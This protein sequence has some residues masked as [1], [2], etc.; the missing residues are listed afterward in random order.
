MSLRVRESDQ[1]RHIRSLRELIPFLRDE[2]DWPIESEDP[3]EITFDYEPKDLGIDE[4]A[5]VRIKEIKQLRPLAG[6]QPWGI[7]WVSFEKKRLPIVVLRRIL[8]ALVIKKRAG[9]SD[10]ATWKSHDLLFLSAYGESEHRELAIAHFSE[11]STG[12]SA[13][14]LRVL[15][16]DDDDTALKLD[17][18]LETLRDKLRWDEAFAKD[19]ERWRK[20]WSAAFQLRY[21]H[22]IRTSQELATALA[23]AA[24]RIKG[25][26]RSILRHEDGL[27]EMRKLQRAFQQ[28]LI[29]DLDDEAFSDMFAQ[30]VTYGLFSMACRRTIPGEGT[31]FA[32]EDLQHYF[33]SPFLKEMF[34]IFL[35]IKTRKGSIDFDELGLSDVTDLLTG[36]DTKMDAVLAD[37]NNKT[38]GEDPVIHFYEHFLNAY[39]K[40]LKVQRGVFYT[41]QPVVSYIVRSVHELLQTEFGLEDGLASTTTWGDFLQ[42]SKIQ[43]PQ[44]E[45]SL[46]PLTDEPGCKETISPN[47]PFVQILDPATGTATFLVEVIDVIHK[48]LKAKWEKGGPVAM[49]RMECGHPA[50]LVSRGGRDDHAPVSPF[51]DPYSDIAIHEHHLP[52][53][54]QEEVFYFVTWRLADSLPASWLADWQAEKDAWLRHHPQP[55]DAETEAEYHD[56]F[57]RR[58]DDWLDSGHGSCLLREPAHAQIVADAFHHFDGQRYDL[59][60]FVIMPNHVHVLFR[61]KAGEALEKTLHSWKSFTAKTLNQAAGRSGSLWQ[62]DYWDRIIRNERHLAAV[63]GY[64]ERNPKGKV[65]HFW[66]R[67]AGVSPASHQ[68]SGQDARAPVTP[69]ASFDDYWN[70]YVPKSLL[71]RLHAYE[72]MMAPYAIAH[73]KIGLKLAETGYRFESDTR[74]RIYLTNALEPWQKQLRLPEFEALAH[75]AAAVNE[76]KRQKRF[77]V[78]IGNP[79]YSYMSANLT[80]AAAGLIEPFRYVDG[81][82]IREKSAL[83]LERSLQDDFV[84]FFGLALR[85]RRDTGPSF[86]LGFITNNS[87][88]DSPLHRGVRGELMALLS[89]LILVNLF[90][91]S[92]KDR[93]E[94]VF[95]IQQGV[96][97]LLGAKGFVDEGAKVFVSEV[98]GTRSEKYGT[99]QKQSWRTTGLT[100]VQPSAPDRYFLRLDRGGE[101]PFFKSL[102]E[103]FQLTSTCIKTL[104]DSLATGFGSKEVH[105]NLEYFRD[106]RSSSNEIKVLFGVDDV[107][108]WKMEPAR[109]AVR[110]LSLKDFITQYQARPFDYRWMFYHKAIVGSP[111]TEVMRNLLK[112]KNIALIA[113]RK[114]RTG[115]CNHFWVS[116]S[117]CVSEIISSADNSNCFPLYVL[118]DEGGLNLGEDSRP[119]FSTTFLKLLSDSFGVKQTGRTGIP[120]CLT[121]EDIFHYIYAVFHSPSYRTRYA[122]FLKIDFPRLP[123]TGNL[124][125]F[126]ALAILGGELTA[127]HLLESPKLGHPITNFTGPANPDVTK[128]GWTPE[129][130]GTVWLDAGGKKSA[131]IA[132]TVGF[133]GVPE[134]VWKFHI[135]GYQVC[136]KWLKDRKGR[137]LSA[138]DIAHYHKIVVAL[139]ET[140]RLMAEIDEVINAHGGWPGAFIASGS[141]SNQI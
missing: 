114:I 105:N 94:N 27:G 21:R 138:D 87:Y 49:P 129:N 82:R 8:R 120:S 3:E 54:Q 88:L 77:T 5:A 117:I 7:F 63:R 121:P 123:L 18:V 115:E 91:D 118:K 113:N 51:L 60:S 70:E 139:S 132:G 15:Q 92:I 52:H 68:G 39:N 97:V 137:Q 23:S 44:S 80:S 98:H 20:E 95:D 47:E 75:E 62:E 59:D 57:S 46:P 106:V 1:L 130:G 24:K 83:S 76:I 66:K 85:L 36:E 48:H 67:S 56:R 119:N 45:I 17:D 42:K 29:A 134:C 78:V 50:R 61:L 140:I 116:S 19:H 90:G 81:Q 96:A 125:L 108:Q 104:K 65:G 107:V 9:S 124:E 53:W 136:E 86:I 12:L 72:L 110:N 131:T 34:E 126:R 133:Q 26:I 64:I 69:F 71:P 109:R 31:A 43:N 4:A 32:K 102:P 100:R 40:K 10:R 128:V 30:T 73:M 127:L 99:M 141:E 6:G 2:L 79:P 33:T 58:I 84:K 103:V 22:A 55:W 111:R 37:F 122:E 13:A 35:G 89:E 11:E 112:T 14:T 101:Y 25:R 74:A 38:R 28:T 93:E 41:P 16:W 135:G